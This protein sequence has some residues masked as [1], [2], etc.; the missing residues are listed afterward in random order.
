MEEL[1]QQ[2]HYAGDEQNPVP[3]WIRAH[4]VLEQEFEEFNAHQKEIE[5]LADEAAHQRMAVRTSHC[6]AEHLRI[7]VVSA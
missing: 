4:F 2:D 7:S 6:H 1:E 3:S 5:A